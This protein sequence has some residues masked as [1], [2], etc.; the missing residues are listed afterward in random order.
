MKSDCEKKGKTQP[1]GTHSSSLSREEQTEI[2]DEA[3][4]LALGSSPDFA[5]SPYSRTSGGLICAGTQLQATEIRLSDHSGG[6]A[7]DL[8]PLPFHPPEWR[9]PISESKNQK[10][11]I[12]SPWACQ[13]MTR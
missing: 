11:S 5:P 8:H 10:E 4:F 13:T 12:T 2:S 9:H 6:T 3:G 7:W 1:P